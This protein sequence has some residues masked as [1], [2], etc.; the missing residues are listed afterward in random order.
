MLNV[1][2]PVIVRPAAAGDIP[3]M[4]RIIDDYARR[5]AMLARREADILRCLED[6]I[7]AC[8]RDRTIGCGALTRYSSRIGEI[9]SVAVDPAHARSGAGRRIV[10]SLVQR[11][12]ELEI[13]R[14]YLLTL[15]PGFFEKAGFEVVESDNTSLAYLSEAVLDQS[16][17]F[18]NKS[19][20]M[21]DL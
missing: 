9:R 7:V 19:L 4:A 20:M 13:R 10:E 6:F 16:R 15:V 18:A 21:R 12:R 3:T 8:K 11:A 2:A 5:R 14:V 17:S 1:E